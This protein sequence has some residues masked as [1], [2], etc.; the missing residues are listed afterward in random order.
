MNA[1]LLQRW[2][3]L[4][5]PDAHALGEALIRAWDEPARVYHDQRHLVW[6]LDEAKRRGALI[7]DPAFV[8]YA[9]WFHDAVYEPGRPDNETLSA[10]WAR[11]SLAHDVTLAERV[12]R[13]IEMTKDHASG[14]A[15]GDE[16]LF[17]DMDIAILGA[18]WEQYCAYAAGI[19]AEYPHV[20][21]P[22]F[23]GGRGAFLAK[24]LERGRTFRTDMYEHEL[25][26]TARANMRWELEEMRRG[27]MVKA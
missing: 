26:E 24:Q 14:A 1:D 3:A 20:V 7:G 15:S 12:G 23:A 8:G 22:A 6:L 21:D 5:G 4:A 11:T 18:P 16:A 2:R 10:D 19:R 13:V 25:G 9:I 27:R 17:L